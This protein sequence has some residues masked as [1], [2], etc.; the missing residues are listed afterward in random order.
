MDTSFKNLVSDRVAA[1]MDSDRPVEIMDKAVEKLLTS[2]IEDSL[3]SYSD[4][5]KSL[6]DAVKAAMPANIERA[7]D[8]QKYNALIA[9][10]LKQRWEHSAFSEQLA[11]QASAAIDEILSS[12][13]MLKGEVKLSEL[14]EAFID[15]NKEQAHEEQWEAPVFVIENDDDRFIHI[16]FD[17]DPDKRRLS[18]FSLSHRIAISVKETIKPE[19]SWRHTEYKGSVYSAMLDDEKIELNMNLYSRWERIIA[20]L[21]FGNAQ[22]HIDCDPDDF[23]YGIYG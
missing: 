6:K 13:G 22:L 18:N 19:E 14:I 16:Y 17:E 4:F 3:S 7:I 23:N 10:Q 21:Y 2:V 8:L 15:A 12:G 20:S 1:F 5:G 11:G 9:T